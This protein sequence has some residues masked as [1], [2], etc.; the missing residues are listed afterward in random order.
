MLTATKWLSHRGC[1]VEMPSTSFL[2]CRKIRKSRNP[3]A[4]KTYMTNSTRFKELLVSGEMMKGSAHLHVKMQ[5][6]AWRWLHFLRKNVFHARLRTRVIKPATG[7]QLLTI[8]HGET[9]KR[10]SSVHCS[11]TWLLSSDCESM[12]LYFFFH[13]LIYIYCFVRLKFGYTIL[14]VYKNLEF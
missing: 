11:I 2:H 10:Y 3:T 6:R 1:L 12:E 9:G 13:W 14:R 8:C 5:Q 4:S 7:T